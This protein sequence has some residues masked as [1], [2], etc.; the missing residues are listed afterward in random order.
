MISVEGYRIQGQIQFALSA[1]HSD[2]P[3]RAVSIVGRLPQAAGDGGIWRL[4]NLF[5]R[6]FGTCI[7]D[8]FR[9]RFAR[10]LMIRLFFAQVEINN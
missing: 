5:R 3:S 2:Y 9:R 6:R 1:M 7:E 8:A 10:D 4:K